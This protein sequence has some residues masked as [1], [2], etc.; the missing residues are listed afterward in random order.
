MAST[1]DSATPASARARC[2]VGTIASRWARL[3]TSGTTPPNRACSSTLDAT[4][5]ASRVCP[6]TIPTPVSSQ[7][8]SMPSTRGSSL[9]TPHH[10]RVGV[11]RLVV[12]ATHADGLEAVVVVEPLG[13]TVVHGHLQED[14]RAAPR[15]GLGQ[16]GL[17]QP[18]ADPVPLAVPP[19][20]EVLYSRLPVAQRQPRVPDDL[21][22]GLLTRTASDVHPI[23]V[24]IGKF[25]PEHRRRPLLGA[26]Q[27]RLHRQHA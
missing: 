26:E 8:V 21:A 1:S 22:V 15:G 12:P 19:Y 18:P 20:R 17:H 9:I 25:V 6:R 4:A 10:Q 11:R 24:A 14:G 7:D 5:S 13:R 16:Q 27:V 2:I 3:A 23:E